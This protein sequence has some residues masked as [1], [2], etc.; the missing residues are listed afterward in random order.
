MRSGRVRNVQELSGTVKRSY[1]TRLTVRNFYEITLTVQSQYNHGTI[2]EQSWNN[3]GTITVR[4][5]YDHVQ[6]SKSK[7]K[8]YSS[9]VNRPAKSS[10]LELTIQACLKMPGSGRFFLHLKFNF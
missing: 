7:E 5:W 4:S 6:A 3:H 1:C 2:M 9:D 10:D 8:L